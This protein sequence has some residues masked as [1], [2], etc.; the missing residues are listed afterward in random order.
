MTR[1]KVIRDLTD[2]IGA[3]DLVVFVGAGVNGRAGPSW[4]DLIGQILREATLKMTVK[5]PELTRK[6]S[7]AL[8]AWWGKK[9]DPCATAAI[10]KYILDQ[11]FGKVIQSIL[12]DGKDLDGKDKFV[13]QDLVN[14]CE[15]KAADGREDKYGYLKQ[16]ALLCSHEKVRAVVSF[17]Y[18]TFLE[19]AVECLKQRVPIPRTPEHHQSTS[20]SSSSDADSAKY[21]Y[22]H[23]IHGYVPEPDMKRSSARGRIALGSREYLEQ[24]RAPTSWDTSTPLHFLRNHCCL[25]L[26]VSFRDWNMLRLVEA[27]FTGCS[28]QCCYCIVCE[29]DLV[30]RGN[31]ALREQ[32]MQLHGILLES[33]GVRVINAGKDFKDVRKLVGEVARRLNKES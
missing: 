2:A 15:A 27:A 28:P 33:V 29:K 32:S 14:H 17:N 23:H 18:D 25:F 30:H 6:Q 1:E 20:P 21:L 4:D 26:G 31:A 22:V 5:V 3:H 16:T 7:D 19:K 8:I 24:M 13:E 9:Y 11:R 10:A 12:Y